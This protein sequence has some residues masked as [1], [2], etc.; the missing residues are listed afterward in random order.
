M[1]RPPVEG[2]VLNDDLRFKQGRDQGQ[3][4]GEGRRPAHLRRAD[5][6]QR[7]I[8]GRKGLARV[9]Q[10][11]EHLDCAVVP[12]T[13]QPDLAQARSIGIGGL[14]IQRDKAERTCGKGHAFLLDRCAVRGSAR[15]AP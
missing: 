4:L 2:A 14:D 13:G 1:D 5:A 15:Q 11:A 12:D 9:D 8:E 6:V 7:Q 10:R 3:D